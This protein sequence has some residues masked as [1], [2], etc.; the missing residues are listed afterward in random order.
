MAR[1]WQEIL[2]S[3]Q[4]QSLDP[5]KQESLRNEY[6]R[7]VVAPSVATED[8]DTVRAAFDEETAPRDERRWGEALADTGLQLAEGTLNVVGAPVSLLAP[9]SGAAAGLEGAGEWLRGQQSLVLRNKQRAA[10]A[11]V[12][13]AGEK[14]FWPQLWTGL[15]EYGGDPALAARLMTTTLPS[16]VPVLGAGRLAQMGSLARS[17]RA[18][19]V[20]PEALEGAAKVDALRRAQAAALAAAGGTNA[21]LN[22]GGARQEAYAD[23]R[24]TLIDQG[25][26]PAEAERIAVGESRTPALVGGVA[27]F[28]AGRMGVEPALAGRALGQGGWRA[29]LA[30]AG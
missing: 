20:A 22:A 1:S 13:A 19:G 27:G 6:F 18:A 2:E 16:M 17:A 4:F 12:E 9:D 23:V 10:D 25:V 7:F 5:R 21:V 11:K 15:Q 26:D 3:P 28:L 8:L 29:G 24:Q 30:A 14:G